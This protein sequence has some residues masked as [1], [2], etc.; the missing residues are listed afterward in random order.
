MKEIISITG[1]LGSGKSTVAHI[2]C[3]RLGMEYY[4]TGKIQRAIAAKMGIDTLELNRRSKLDKSVDDLIDNGLRKMNEDDTTMIIVNSRLA[5]FFI[6]KSFKVFLTCRPEVAAQRVFA[7]KERSS[8]PGGEQ[9]KVM[10]NLLDRQKEENERFKL[11]YGADCA[12]RANFNFV[13]DT[14][15]LTPNEV[16]DRIIAAY[17]TFKNAA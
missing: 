3:E 14:S 8:E 10:Q 6:S 17:E 2:L 13:L 5:W 11:F 1:D 9:M 16:A 7:D 12:N 4:S 15:D